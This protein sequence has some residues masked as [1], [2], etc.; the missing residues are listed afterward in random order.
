LTSAFRANPIWARL[1]TH[2]NKNSKMRLKLLRASFIFLGV[3]GI[4]A[5]KEIG[6]E[7]QVVSQNDNQWFP[8]SENGQNILF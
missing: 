4:W 2:Q 8:L 7:E 6:K 5:A 3:H 1:D